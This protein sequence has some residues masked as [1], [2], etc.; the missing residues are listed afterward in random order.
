M[1]RFFETQ[2]SVCVYTEQRRDE[3]MK[4][5]RKYADR[6]PVSMPLHDIRLD[7]MSMT[8]T[9]DLSD[10]SSIKCPSKCANARYQT[11]RDVNDG[12]CGSQ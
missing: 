11:R 9:V 5:R 8:A 2:C 6:V 4:I 3:A 7:V 10:T 12:N 1:G